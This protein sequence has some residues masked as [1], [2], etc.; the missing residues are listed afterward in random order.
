MV[1]KEWIELTLCDVADEILELLHKKDNQPT[2]I[3]VEIYKI[4]SKYAEE[5]FLAQK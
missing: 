5:I 2:Q 4:L 1:I 3:R